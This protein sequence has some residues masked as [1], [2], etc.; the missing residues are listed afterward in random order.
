MD[1]NSI[2]VLRNNAARGSCLQRKVDVTRRVE[3]LVPPTTYWV[4]P[5]T[6][7]AIPL[8][9]RFS[10]QHILGTLTNGDTA[11]DHAHGRDMV[12]YTLHRHLCEGLHNSDIRFLF[13]VTDALEYANHTKH[14]WAALVMRMND[15]RW[16]KA[17]IEWYPREKKR[18]LGR[19]QSGGVTLLRFD[20]TSLMT[21][22]GAAP[23]GPQEL[24]AETNGKDATIRNNHRV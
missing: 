6:C 13:K 24:E 11:G 10:T 16:S 8:M 21:E 7:C 18:T 15:G 1:S 5:I 4:G 23:T 12:C 14:R 2:H 22:W 19:P 3:L 17:V 20:I 9:C